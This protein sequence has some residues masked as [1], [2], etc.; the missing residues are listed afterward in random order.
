[1][2]L[3]PEKKDRSYQFGRLLAVMEKVERDSY[4]S[5]EGREPNAIRLQS[6]FCQR[7]MYV[8]G[9]VEKQLE[10]AY[11]PRLK[12]GSRIWYK[13]LMG[14]IMT[15]ISEFPQEDWNKPLEESYLMGYYLQRSALYT[16]KTDNE[17]EEVEA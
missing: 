6:V 9:M 11:Y 16:K 15:V 17:V 8:A 14:E 4:G 2:A 3:D 1:M 5:E 10:R 7:P 13:N 12:I